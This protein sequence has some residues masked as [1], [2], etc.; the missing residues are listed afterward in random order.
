M[1]AYRA[2]RVSLLTCF[3]LIKCIFSIT[4][5]YKL[6]LRWPML[7]N[8]FEP[9]G[10]NCVTKGGEVNPEKTKYMLMS[11]YQKAGRRH[12]IMIANRWFNSR[13][14]RQILIKIWCGGY[15]GYRPN[16]ILRYLLQSVTTPLQTL[17][18]L[19]RKRFCVINIIK[20]QSRYTP[21]RCLGERG[22]RSY[23]FTT[24]ELD[25]G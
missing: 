1:S 11:R 18:L 3:R 23:S 17:E 6:F 10:I 9:S 5:A 16:I 7:F 24:S 13:T 12:S 20:N 21:R 14:A 15:V 22:Y 19:R 2:N 8:P 25:G 4:Y